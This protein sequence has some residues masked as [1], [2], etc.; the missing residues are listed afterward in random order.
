ME[1]VRYG[2]CLTC[3]GKKYDDDKDSDLLKQSAGGG[4]AFGWWFNY[5]LITQHMYSYVIWTN[6]VK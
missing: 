1:Y 5:R 3:A 2:I 4:N 6:S